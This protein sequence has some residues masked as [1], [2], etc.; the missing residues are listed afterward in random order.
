MNSILVDLPR[1]TKNRITYSYSV[2]GEW[3]EAFCIDEPFFIEYNCDVSNVPASIALVPLLTNLLPIAWVYDAEIKIPVCDEDFY[4]SISDFKKGYMT[5]YPMI[6]FK[7]KLTVDKLVKAKTDSVLQGAAAFFS[8]G[9]DAFDTLINHESEKPILITLWGSDIKLDDYEG[10]SKVRDHLN[11]TCR[12]FNVRGITVKSS[13]RRFLNEG[14]LGEKVR[15]SGDG[16]W[17]GFQHGIGLIGHAAP[18]MYVFKKKMLYIASTFVEGDKTTCASHPSIDNYV[19][20][21]G[22]TV[23]HDGYKFSRQDKVRNIVKYAKKNQKKLPLRVCWQSSGG[24]NCCNCEKCWRTILEIYSEGFDPRDFGFEYQYISSI[25]DMMRHNIILLKPRRKQYY[26]LAQQA[27]RT[28]YS[29]RTVDSSLKWFYKVN[30]NRLGDPPLWKR[31]IRKI[32][33]CIKDE[34]R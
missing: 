20:F 4:Q 7:G 15:I 34:K 32:I 25:G 27:M 2:K 19:R 12:E 8:G 22:G 33:R 26:E 30:I 10:W 14:Q 24:S 28:N 13:F 21:C 29:I 5:M 6:D 11:Q 31:A 16:W 18:I 1:I 9:V 3:Q 23:I 17:H